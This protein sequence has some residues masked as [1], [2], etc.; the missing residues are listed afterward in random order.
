MELKGAAIIPIP[1]SINLETVRPLRA[2]LDSAFADRASDVVVLLGDDQVFCRGLELGRSS[3]DQD[4]RAPV[5]SFASCLELIRTGTKPVI[6][7]VRGAAA[8]AGVGLAA[9]CDGLLAATDATFTLPELLL[10]LTPAVI[11]P[12]L[13]QRVHLQR[14][15]WMGLTAQT[16]S[17]ET[18]AAF[19]LVDDVCPT[20]RASAVLRS[21]IRKLRRVNP[22]VI[23]LWKRMTIDAPL[24]G[25]KAGVESLL[26]RFADAHVRQGLC[27]FFETGEPPW[28]EKDEP[29][30]Y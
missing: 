1:Q 22:K 6:G 7:F 12:F 18:A 24:P 3:I 20:D 16:I 9:A 23:R 4:L 14:L 5:E 21:W 27:A 30:N 19:G 29:R 13:A 8:G 2:A 26:E 25:S 10:G 11:L 28:M 15:R 17:A